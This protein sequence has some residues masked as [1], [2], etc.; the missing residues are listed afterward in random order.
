MTALIRYERL[1]SPALWREAPEAQRRDVILSFGDASLVISDSA[2]RVLTHW[3]LAAIARTNPGMRPAIFTPDA[4]SGETLEVDEP[5]M[6]EAIE[7]VRAAIARGRPRPGR[8]R[9]AILG[10]LLAGMTALALFWLPGA[11]VRHA[12]TVLPATVRAEIGRDVLARLTRVAGPACARPGGAAALDRLTM[13]LLPGTS[14]KVIV[15]PGGMARAAHLPG[16]LILLNRALV[17]DFE[18]PGAVAGFILAEDARATQTDPLAALLRAAGP[19][20]TLR[21]LTSGTLPKGAL[22]AHAE[23]VMTHPPAPL[24]DEALLARFAKAGLSSARYAYALDVSGE[25]VLGLIEADPMRGQIPVPLIS[26]GDWVR[27]QSICG[28]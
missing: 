4:D 26:D 1:E 12:V 13:R 18:D 11:L 10:V 20:A 6:I 27:L 2:E 14:T 3:S 9:L 17:E 28:G 25:T 7:A 23:A 15:L 24:P 16:G 22:D 8:L 5:V 19:L 21:L